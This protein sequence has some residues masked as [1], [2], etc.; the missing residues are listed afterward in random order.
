VFV[1]SFAL[2]S[3]G[4]LARRRNFM[5]GVHMT[6]VK[7]AETYRLSKKQQQYFLNI[8]KEVAKASSCHSR[9]IGAVLITQS[10]Q[11]I[12]TGY[13]GPPRGVTHCG[14]ARV[15]R[16][17]VLNKLAA[18]LTYEDCPR[19]LL[20]YDSGQGLQICP[21]AHAE[22]NALIQAA[23]HGISTEATI[24]CLTC[25]I[26]CKD[27]LIEIIN[28]GVRTVYVTSLEHYDLLSEY[29]IEESGIQIFQYE[30]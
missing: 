8:A 10:G 13:N 18:I 11:I 9:K 14:T 27:C 21:A 23:R 17:K 25:C 26:P 1:A 12:S 28:A 6:L 30:E 20:H 19:R 3:N 29:L 24:L 4:I 7:S 5:S 22:R 16:D 15:P 2:F